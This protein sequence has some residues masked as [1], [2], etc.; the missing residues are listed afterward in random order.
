MEFSLFFS[1]LDYK[2]HRFNEV[3]K[4]TLIHMDWLPKLL[5][6]QLLSRGQ[7]PKCSENNRKTGADCCQEAAELFLETDISQG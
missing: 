6:S 2:F 3:S 7:E 4:I 5:K 1:N